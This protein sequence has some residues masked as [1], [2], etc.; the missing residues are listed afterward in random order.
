MKKT[1]LLRRA[2]S[3]P[4][5]KSTIEIFTMCNGFAVAHNRAIVVYCERTP[6]PKKYARGLMMPAVK[7]SIFS[8]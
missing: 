8:Y 5:I 6:T 2:P 4:Y 7:D 1:F 3:I